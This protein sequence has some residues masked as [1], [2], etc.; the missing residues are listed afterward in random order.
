MSTRSILEEVAAE[1]V[2]QND[3]WGEQNHADGTGP[4]AELVWAPELDLQVRMAIWGA[5]ERAGITEGRWTQFSMLQHV[6]K[7]RVDSAAE[8]G[9]STYRDILLEEVFKAL[10]CDDPAELRAELIQTAAVCVQWL[11]AID[12]RT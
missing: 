9:E 8:Q 4:R 3:K 7:H 5:L 2:R 12:R 1:R 10:A 11:E 6:L